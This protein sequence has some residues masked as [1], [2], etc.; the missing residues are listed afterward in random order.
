MSEN[1]YTFGSLERDILRLRR[2]FPEMEVGT[3]G[4]S[5]WGKP[6]YYIKIGS[7]PN[8]ISYNGAHHGMEAI[9]SACLMQFVR[10]FLTAERDGAPLGGFCTTA[11][12]K[13][14]SVYVVPMLNPDGVQL[15]AEGLPD[16]LDKNER[17]RLIEMCGSEDFSEWQANAHGVDL[18]HN[19]DAMWEKSKAMEAEYGILSPGLTR[20]SG[21]CAES[22]PESRALADF[23]RLHSFKMVIALHSQGR[24]IYHGFCDKEPPYAPEIARA[25]T[26]ISPYSLDSTE[27]IASYAGYKDWFIS[28][29]NRPG[30]T[31]EVGEGRNPLP[32]SD[33]PQIYRDTLPILLGA[34]TVA[35]P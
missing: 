11:L 13:K 2:D 3:I 27:G 21:S 29:F 33:L 22:E 10:E 30:F 6:L 17:E 31:V 5:V 4:T 28:R 1:K 34:M 7:G 8:E 23:T 35:L 15:A 18:N 14:T 32:L 12:A 19:Y 20:F 24:V 9:T 16:G 26:R 25:F